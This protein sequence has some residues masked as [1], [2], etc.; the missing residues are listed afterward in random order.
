MRH[1]DFQNRLEYIENYSN[2]TGSRSYS[3]RELMIY[4]ANGQIEKIDL[5]RSLARQ[6]EPG[7]VLKL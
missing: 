1:F 4:N 5:R 2:I 7:A 6:Y 3:G